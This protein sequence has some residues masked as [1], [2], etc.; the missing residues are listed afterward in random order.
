MTASFL[1]GPALW[2]ANRGTGFVL[3]VLL[4]FSMMLGV[5]STSRMSPRLWPRM[6]TQGLHRNVSMLAVTFLGAHV[7]TAVVDTFVDIR[8]WDAFVPFSGT[9]KPVWLG[10]GTLSLDL[11]IAVTATSLLRHRMS[12]RPWRSIHLLAYVSW[13]MGLL[14]GLQIGTDAGAAWGV[15]LNYGCVGAVALSVLVRCGL[16]VRPRLVTTS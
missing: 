4:T 9:Y 2:F 5:L 7:V 14:H 6:L 13:G 8:W 15:A 16:L 1:D 10:Y 3:L 12:H 11:L